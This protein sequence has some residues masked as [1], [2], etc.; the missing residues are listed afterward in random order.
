M[1]LKLSP[2]DTLLLVIDVQERLLP[3]M[4]ERFRDRLVENL[5]KLGRA[6]ECL[7]FPVLMTEQYPQGLG[8]TV[9]AVKAAFPDAAPLP[10]MCFSVDGDVAIQR[11]LR[12]ANRPN[13]V[14]AGMETHICVYQSVRALAASHRVHVLSDAVA[15]RRVEDRDVGLELMARAGGIVTS[16]EVVL[17]DFLERAGTEAFKLLSHILP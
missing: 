7:G 11:A 10:K 13:I 9:A 3:A 1:E 5:V 15:S 17:F 6:R 8:A 12:E 16:T 2:E 4:N 14:V